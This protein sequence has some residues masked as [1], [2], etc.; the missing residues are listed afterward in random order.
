MS[1]KAPEF[2]FINFVPFGD[3]SLSLLT[4]LYEEYAN[5]NSLLENQILKSKAS[6]KIALFPTGRSAWYR[7]FMGLIAVNSVL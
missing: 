5:H 2:S 1:A 7:R 6:A 4:S 3:K